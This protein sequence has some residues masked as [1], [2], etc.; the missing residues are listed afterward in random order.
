MQIVRVTV[1]YSSYSGFQHHFSF[2]NLQRRA[3]WSPWVNFED[4]E[5][6]DDAVETWIAVSMMIRLKLRNSLC[7]NELVSDFIN[8]IVRL[9]FRTIIRNILLVPVY[10]SESTSMITVTVSW[11][12][13]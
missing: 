9:I 3:G 12:A 5:F 4:M 7:D 2:C 6:D 10:K 11:F 13:C 1:D 8:E